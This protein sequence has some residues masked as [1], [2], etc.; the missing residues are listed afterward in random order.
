MK[1]VYLAHNFKAASWLREEVVPILK[2]SNIEVTS[3]WLNKLQTLSTDAGD[4]GNRDEA[5]EDLSDLR[6][7]DALLFFCDQFGTTPGRGKYFELGFAYADGIP[8]LIVGSEE[9]Y[10]NCVFN[11][12][13][14]R[15]SSI[16]EAIEWFERNT[17]AGYYGEEKR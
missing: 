12:L 14:D 17:P 9:S 4:Q 13:F 5:L 2:A 15:V 1:R 3:S 7:S 11:S 8:A 16:Q 10:N 6:C